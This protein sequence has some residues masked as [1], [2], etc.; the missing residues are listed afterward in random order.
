VI[1]RLALL[2][3]CTLS[4]PASATEILINYPSKAVLVRM[5]T[6]LG[7]YDPV[8]KTIVAQAR[9]DAGGDYFF[10]NV[11]QFVAIP[12]VI[13]PVTRVE[14]SPAV[15]APGLWARLRHNADPAS[16]AAKIAQSATAAAALGI[17]IYRRLP[18]GPKD[19]NGNPTL[20]WSA[21]NSTCGPAYLDL[22]GVIA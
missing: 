21:D 14:T 18:L 12:A 16:L 19:S 8:G 13:D 5:A 1:R 6:A 9:V 22:I 4:L 3:L 20:C 10:N 7:Y 15:M 17:L 11:G 2:T